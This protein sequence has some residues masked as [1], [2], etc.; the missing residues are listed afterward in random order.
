MTDFQF[1][2]RHVNVK[3]RSQKRDSFFEL[4]KKKFN[5]QFYEI[6]YQCCVKHYNE[7]YQLN[8]YYDGKK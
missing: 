1:L 5:F 4:I 6:Q 2:A 3:N 8:Q 7:N